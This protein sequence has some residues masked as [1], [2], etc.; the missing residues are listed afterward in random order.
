MVRFV[1]IR[2]IT[3]TSAPVL[4]RDFVAHK[5]RGRLAQAEQAVSGRGVVSVAISRLVPLV[6]FC[7]SNAGVL[8]ATRA[9]T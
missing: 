3:C 7:V 2:A 4:G 5:L 8:V 1:L 6:P 9:R